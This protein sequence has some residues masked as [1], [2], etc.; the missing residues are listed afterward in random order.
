MRP[1]SAVGCFISSM[2]VGVFLLSSCSPHY[3]APIE[4]GWHSKVGKASRYVVQ[5]GDTLY[6]IAWSFGYDYRALAATNNLRSPYILERGQTL[7]MS[8]AQRAVQGV[9]PRKHQYKPQSQPRRAVNTIN[10]GP[11]KLRWPTSGK[12]VSQFSRKYGGNKGIDIRGLYKQFVIAAGSGLV[13]YAGSGLRGYGQLIIV[14]HSN[15]YLSAYANNA[16]ILIR[17]GQ[18]VRSGQKIALMGRDNAGRTR[19]HFELR[20]NGQPVDPMRYLR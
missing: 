17:Q 15:E 9:P 1:L 18:T 3:T 10:M 20:R 7:K 2:T 13:V 16:K 5:R 11:I 14:K 8:V 6:S 12:V 4:D 19:L